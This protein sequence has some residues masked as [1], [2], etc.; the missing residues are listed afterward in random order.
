MR[1]T[2]LIQPGTIFL[3]IFKTWPLGLSMQ[4]PSLK[5]A[6]RKWRMNTFHESKTKV[7]CCCLLVWNL[8]LFLALKIPYIYLGAHYCLVYFLIYNGVCF[9]CYNWRL[10]LCFLDA[11]IS[12]NHIIRMSTIALCGCCLS[13]SFMLLLLNHQMLLV[14]ICFPVICFP[15]LRCI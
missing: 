9:W 4:V 5:N 14:V 1:K 13:F 11:M 3:Q 12:G 2:T 15:W 6:W 7:H 8:K 10:D